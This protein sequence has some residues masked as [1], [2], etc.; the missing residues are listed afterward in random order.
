[1]RSAQVSAGR[2][3]VVALEP[4]AEVLAAIGALCGQYQFRAAIVPVFFGA[5]TRVTLIGT[6]E[7]VEDEDEDA[8]K[9]PSQANRKVMPK[10]VL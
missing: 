3:L 4:G 1:V 7:P 10:N 5:F 9:A 6:R 2:R 8:L